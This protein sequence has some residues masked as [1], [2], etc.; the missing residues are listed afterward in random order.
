MDVC[1]N[2]GLTVLY[3]PNGTSETSSGPLHTV[4]ESV[5]FMPIQQLRDVSDRVLPA[6]WLFMDLMVTR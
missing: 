1:H 2:Y 3:Q 6:W 5:V 4:F